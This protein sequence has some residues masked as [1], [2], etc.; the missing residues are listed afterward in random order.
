MS[1][2]QTAGLCVTPVWA[3][4]VGRTGE[5]TQNGVREAVPVAEGAGERD[6]AGA[7]VGTAH[8]GRVRGGG[9]FAGRR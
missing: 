7:A 8:D 3:Q 4:R 6:G 9:F 1:S 5:L 2:G